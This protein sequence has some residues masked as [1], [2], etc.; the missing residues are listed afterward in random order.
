MFVKDIYSD[1]I[2]LFILKT[3]IVYQMCYASASHCGFN[4]KYYIILS[5]YS[6]INRITGI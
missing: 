4:D 6:W 2:Y 1:I 5:D 3:S